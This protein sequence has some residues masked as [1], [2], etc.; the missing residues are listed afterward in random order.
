MAQHWGPALL[1]ALTAGHA[2]HVLP[3]IRLQTEPGLLLLL[4]IV[5]SLLHTWLMSWLSLCGCALMAR[6]THA[7]MRCI[8]SGAL[9]PRSAAAV[10]QKPV[11]LAASEPG[12]SPCNTPYGIL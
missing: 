8:T 7:P 5:A 9:Q 11:A 6:S 1:P 12:F 4:Q 3:H 2:S 10:G